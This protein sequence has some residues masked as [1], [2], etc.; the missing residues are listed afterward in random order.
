MIIAISMLA[1]R[2]TSGS[3]SYHLL[4]FCYFFM[5]L[6][7]L[8]LPSWFFCSSFPISFFVIRAF[9][10][11]SFFFFLVSFLGIN[12]F[13][14]FFSSFHSLRLEWLSGSNE[15]S[16]VCPNDVSHVRHFTFEFLKIIFTI[17]G[18]S[19]RFVWL[20]NLRI[21]SASKCVVLCS[22]KTPIASRYCRVPGR[23]VESKSLWVSFHLHLPTRPCCDLASGH[24]AEKVQKLRSLFPSHLLSYGRKMVYQSGK[25]GKDFAGFLK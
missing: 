6:P 12:A 14:L 2:F 3:L 15:V 20:V 16:W 8:I 25:R 1:S 5:S 17:R 24:F 18:C 22:N 10:E 19:S 21:S 23:I 4:S 13:V 7:V 11:I 9:K